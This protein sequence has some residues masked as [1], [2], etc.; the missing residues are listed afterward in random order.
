[1]GL[2]AEAAL[3]ENRALLLSPVAPDT[4]VN[5]QRAIWCNQF[6]VKNAKEIWLGHIR[7]GGSLES[8]LKAT[9]GQFPTNLP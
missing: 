5:K 8:I 6:V 4:G 9:P 7:P 3:A 2:P 1:M